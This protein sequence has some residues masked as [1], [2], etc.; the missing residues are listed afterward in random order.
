[1]STNNYGVTGKPEHSTTLCMYTITTHVMYSYGFLQFKRP[2]VE[3][4][5]VKQSLQ[6]ISHNI[7]TVG[8]LAAQRLTRSDVS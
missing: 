7:V 4:E 1:M 5:G 2:I 6:L 3:S 8:D